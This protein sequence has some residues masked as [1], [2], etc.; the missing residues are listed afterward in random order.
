MNVVR[1]VAFQVSLCDTV[2][3]RSGVPASGT[4]GL[5]SVVPPGPVAGDRSFA[6]V[7]DFRGC[8]EAGV[9]AANI[10]GIS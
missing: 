4:G 1:V 7:A 5:F 8:R 6:R 10:K 3:S 9:G 2:D